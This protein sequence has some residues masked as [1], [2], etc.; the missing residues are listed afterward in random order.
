MLFRDNA[1]ALTFQLRVYKLARACMVTSTMKSVLDIGCGNP[2]KLRFLIAPF[3][4]DITGI[5]LSKNVQ[6]INEEFGEWIGCD[7]EKSMPDIDKVF[8]LIIAADIIEHLHEPKKLVELI[9]HVSDEKTLIILSTPAKETLPKNVNNVDHHS[10]FTTEEIKKFLTKSGFIIEQHLVYAQQT[11]K[12]QYD[13]NVLCL[14]LGD[15]ENGDSSNAK[16]SG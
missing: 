13:D 7:I 4:E 8:D 6:H 3:S 2:Q 10:E 1:S 14:R 12:S 11:G 15:K 16:K 5:D 9:K